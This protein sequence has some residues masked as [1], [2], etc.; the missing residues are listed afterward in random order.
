MIAPDLVAAAADAVVR[1]QLAIP[2]LIERELGVGAVQVDGPA[3][4]WDRAC[5]DRVILAFAKQGHPFSANDL[6]ELLPP[7][8]KALISHRL[9]VAARDGLIRRVGKTPSTLKST[10]AHEINVYQGTK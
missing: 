4:E 2:A 6:R 1:N 5:L 9:R 8:R 10:H 3:D 7:V